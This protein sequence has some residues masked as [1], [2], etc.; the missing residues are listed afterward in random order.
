MNGNSDFL[1]D[2]ALLELDSAEV[3]AV[4]ARLELTELSQVATV[5]ACFEWVRDEVAHSVDVRASRLTCTAREVLEAGHGLCFAKCNLLVALLRAQGIPAGYGYQ[6]LRTGG[7]RTGYGL[8]GFVQVFLEGRAGFLSLDPRGNN[9]N[10]TTTFDLTSPRLA[11]EPDAAFGEETLP[12]AWPVPSAA[13]TELLRSGV[14]VER[15]LISLP[16][17]P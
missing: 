15:A 13:V 7:T 10:V 5:R 1:R 17:A 2:D 12:E 4:L 3:R 14:T 6:R 11:Y 16:D 8:H 9:A